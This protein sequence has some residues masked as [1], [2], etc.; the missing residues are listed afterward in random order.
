MN[1]F[2]KPTNC[3]CGPGGF[4]VHGSRWV[5][6]ERRKPP[7]SSRLKC[8]ECGWRW[9][10]TCRYVRELPDHEE[11]SRSG[12][13]DEDVLD[14]IASGTLTVLVDQARVFSFSRGKWHELRT[15]SRHS[16]G[17]EYSFVEICHQGK[18]KKV[19]LH[20]LVWMFANRQIVPDGYDVDH[21]EGK[22][23][24]QP[25]AIDNLQL[26]ESGRNRSRGKPFISQ[27]E[28]IPF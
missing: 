21:I 19:A 26:L 7:K 13:T 2:R 18:K 22:L 11:A 25:N 14:R 23:I 6:I 16:N 17:S 9:W 12:M 10:S 4:Q 28:E 24:D 8:L 20:R 5:V 3:N 27:T 15:V 1:L